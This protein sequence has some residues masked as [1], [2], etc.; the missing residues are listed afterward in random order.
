MKISC[1]LLSVTAACCFFTGCKNRAAAPVPE[2][3]RQRNPGDLEFLAACGRGDLAGVKQCL[4]Q[5]ADILARL[6][7]RSGLVAAIDSGSLEV[8]RF[9][10]KK[11]NKLAVMPDQYGIKPLGYIVRGHGTFASGAERAERLELLDLLIIAGADVEETDDYGYGLTV[12]FF[13]SGRF[14]PLMVEAL[15][16][17]GAQVNRMSLTAYGDSF[18]DVDFTLPI[19]STP[20]DKYQALLEVVPADVDFELFKENIIGIIQVL[21]KHGARH[22]AWAAQRKLRKIT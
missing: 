20:L 6:E 12:I 10:L 4:N 2:Q 9:L 8:M 1:V 14:A 21:K 16:A 3:V 11:E 22:G 19:G 18:C 13:A 15:L 17:R 5:G 7:Y